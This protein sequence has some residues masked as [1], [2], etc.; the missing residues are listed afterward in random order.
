M[1]S[2]RLRRWIFDVALIGVLAY[3]T[4]S[5]IGLALTGLWILGIPMAAISAIA[6]L[7]KVRRSRLWP[8]PWL[9]PTV[10]VIRDD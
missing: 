5:G 1:P 7:A 10:E 2:T 9:D 3:F 6:L 4:L 8:L